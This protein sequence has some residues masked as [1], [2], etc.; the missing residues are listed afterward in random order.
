MQLNDN[1]YYTGLT[2]LALYIAMYAV[3]KTNRSRSLIDDLTSE[4]LLYGDTKIFR[5]VPM[6]SVSTFNPKEDSTLLSRNVAT[7][8]PKGQSDPKE[9]AEDKLSIDPKDKKIIRSTYNLA[10]METAVKSE[11]GVNDFVSMVLSNIEAAKVDYLY[12]M[13]IDDLYSIIPEYTESVTLY[14]LSQQTLPSEIEAG[15]ILNQKRITLACQKVIDSMTHFSTEFN[16]WGLKQAVDMSDLRMIVFQPYK[17]EAVTNLFAELLNSGYI[18]DNFPRPQ[19]IT[20]P[21]TK[22]ADATHYD[23]KLVCLIMHK[24]AY[25]LSYKLQFNASF[26]DGSTLNVNNFMHFWYLRGW[27]KQLPVAAVKIAGE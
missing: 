10:A 4:P 5:S 17:N 23:S 13:I 24:A 3:N 1:D 14:D 12:D 19:L 21:Q 8:V 7:F 26:F 16:G 20:I 15:E 25:Q 18:N 11:Y 27:V 22:A 9:F 6:P 2:N